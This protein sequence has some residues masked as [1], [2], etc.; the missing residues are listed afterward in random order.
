M[1]RA[2]IEVRSPGLVLMG[3]LDLACGDSES[4]FDSEVDDIDSWYLLLIVSVG[5]LCP[6]CAVC[7]DPPPRTHGRR[8]NSAQMGWRDRRE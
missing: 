2:L 5:T 6:D 1:A 7:D 8:R 4:G 3:D